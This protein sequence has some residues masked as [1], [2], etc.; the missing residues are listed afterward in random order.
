M[1]GLMEGVAEALVLVTTGLTQCIVASLVADV[2]PA[3]H[4]GTAFGDRYSER[5]ASAEELA[6]RVRLR[7]T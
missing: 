7:V 2:A 6:E 5:K 4:G 3:E 1:I